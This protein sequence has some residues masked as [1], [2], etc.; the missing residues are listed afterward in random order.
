MKTLRNILWIVAS[1]CVL[2]FIQGCEKQ[3]EQPEIKTLATPVVT[4]TLDGLNVELEWDAIVN[5]TSYEVEYKNATETEYTAAG[6]VNYSPYVVE[7]LDLDNTYDL[8]LIH[9]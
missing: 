9:I 3:E 6:S 8:S 7:G 1:V 2:P 5:A 4:A